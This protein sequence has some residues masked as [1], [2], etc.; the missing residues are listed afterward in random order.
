M[1]VAQ[2]KAQK[3]IKMTPPFLWYQNL[4]TVFIELKFAYRHDVSGCAT[5]FDEKIDVTDGRFYM[6]AYCA[7]T[8][9]NNVFF[10]LSFPFWAK[11]RSEDIKIERVPVGKIVFTLPKADKP[12]RWR[13]IYEEGTKRPA[14]GKLNLAKLTENH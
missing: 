12:A 3:A 6:S 4:N 13:H 10:E 8:H 11:I 7:E 1:K 14:T 5:L 2:R 9:D